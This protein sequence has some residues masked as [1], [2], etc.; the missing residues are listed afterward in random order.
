MHYLHQ[1]LLLCIFFFAS[2]QFSESEIHRA[3]THGGK[4]F[5][6]PSGEIPVSTSSGDGSGST[7][8]RSTGATGDKL[9]EKS[10][11]RDEHYVQAWVC[12]IVASLV[13]GM[14]G[15]F[16]LLLPIQEGPDLQKGAG[17]ARFKCLLSFAVGGLLG[18][19]FLHLLPEAWAHIHPDD[20]MGHMKIG[21]WVLVGILTFLTLEKMFSDE[22]ENKDSKEAAQ[23]GKALQSNDINKLTASLI[24]EQ[25]SIPNGHSECNGSSKT[26]GSVS[27]HKG[28]IDGVCKRNGRLKEKHHMNGNNYSH[29]KKS[30]LEKK[31]RVDNI[32]VTG[33]LNLLANFIDNF[34]H[35]LAVA[36]SFLVS[37][38]VGVLTTIAI[39]LHEIPHEIGDFA[40]LLRSGFD[41]WRA[42]RAQV[43]TATGGLCGAIL[44]LMSESPEKAGASSAWILPFTSG[45]F[46]NIALVTVLPDLL[47]ETN[48]RESIKQVLCLL[49]GIAVMAAVN[50]IAE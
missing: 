34:T 19:V 22:G 28:E 12:S 24:T 3:K 17:A 39:M 46:L 45:G 25:A 48:P 31:D 15:I 11:W 30:D 43:Y 33:Y 36:G 1:L 8:S 35:G 26:N 32:K 10:G 20:H 50:L 9:G 14:A 18:D 49:S 44:A 42:A 13:V 7:E 23:P 6:Y 21:L 27:K 2:V 40:I 5:S 29:Q 47:E 16:P 37:F 4:S 38:K 41:R